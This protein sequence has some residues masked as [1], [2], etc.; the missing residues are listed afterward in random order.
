MEVCI[1]VR[2]YSENHWTADRDGRKKEEEEFIHAGRVSTKN[3]KNLLS[4]NERRWS[5]HDHDFNCPGTLPVDLAMYGK[6]LLL[7]VTS[8]QGLHSVSRRCKVFELQHKCG[9]TFPGTKMTQQVMR[10]PYCLR[11]LTRAAVYIQGVSLVFIRL[12]V[13]QLAN[14][15]CSRTDHSVFYDPRCLP[16]FHAKSCF[17]SALFLCTENRLYSTVEPLKSWQSHDLIF[18]VSCHS[19][20]FK[21]PNEQG[22]T[23]VEI[24]SRDC[25]DLKGSTIQSSHL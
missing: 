13:K 25:Q 22:G 10:K 19:L 7:S 6:D 1:P 24:E 17:I 9:S 5:G 2:L 18:T 20:R 21:S 15:T 12:G 4:M 16:L 11:R 3:W 8:G 14:R 23:R